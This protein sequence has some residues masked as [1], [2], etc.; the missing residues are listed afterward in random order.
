MDEAPQDVRWDIFAGRCCLRPTRPR[1]RT[2]VRNIVDDE[3][4]GKGE[5][6]GGRHTETKLQS[7]P[8]NTRLASCNRLRHSNNH[9]IPAMS[10]IVDLAKVA[11]RPRRKHSPR[12]TA[13]MPPVRRRTTTSRSCISTGALLLFATLCLTWYLRIRA[14]HL[15]S[16]GGTLVMDVRMAIV[17]P[18]AAGER[19]SKG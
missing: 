15:Q 10:F 11:P 14:V 8:T 12:P 9:R 19:G 2:A 5:R 13:S 7:L 18:S 16:G 6:G 17:A 3:G 4:T 1:R